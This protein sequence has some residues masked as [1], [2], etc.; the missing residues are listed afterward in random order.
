M[1]SV[2][3]TYGDLLKDPRWQRKRLEIFQRDDF[4]CQHC[5][6]KH[7]TLNIHHT[8]YVG[9][10]PWQTPDKYLL[11]LC[12]DSHKIETN[13]KW[14]DIIQALDNAGVTRTVV[15]KIIQR[16]FFGTPN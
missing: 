12:E 2:V 10:Y 7:K 4:A 16:Y 8:K 14:C 9:E 15:F 5:G 6:A 1:E 13:L 11:T 3:T